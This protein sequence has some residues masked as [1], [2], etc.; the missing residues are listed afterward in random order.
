MLYFNLIL[1]ILIFTITCVFMYFRW[2]KL[3]LYHKKKPR[4]FMVLFMIL[5]P[6]EELIFLFLYNLDSNLKDMWVNMILIVFLL[7]LVIDKALLEKRMNDKRKKQLRI[8]DE[9]I[10]EKNGVIQYLDKK[11]E[12]REDE[13][14]KL[15]KHVKALK[16]EI[17]EN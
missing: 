7:T 15:I 6:F 12:K 17:K 10:D 2:E 16:K 9:S 5:Y 11:L 1:L 14:K 3:C 13:K 8:L 4:F